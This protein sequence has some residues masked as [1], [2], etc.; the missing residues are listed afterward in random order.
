MPKE[1]ER[2]IEKQGGA[3]RYRSFKRDG[4]LFRLAVTRHEG[5][6]GGKTVA[7]KVK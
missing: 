3:V 1:A 5:P 2:K 6:K 4:I 7:W